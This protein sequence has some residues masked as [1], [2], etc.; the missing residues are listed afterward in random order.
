MD[1]IKYTKSLMLSK[2]VE[3][4]K[5]FELTRNEMIAIAMRTKSVKSI[6][7]VNLTNKLEDTISTLILNFDEISAVLS[8]IHSKMECVKALTSLQQLLQSNKHDDAKV[9]DMLNINHNVLLESSSRYFEN[10]IEEDKFIDDVYGKE[11][12]P[13]EKN[14][15]KLE[16][17]WI[18]GYSPVEVI[19]DLEEVQV[20]DKD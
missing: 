19:N 10:E 16:E 3:F 7:D 12:E 8:L 6:F 9:M 13:K 2:G 20:W 1:G 15:K 5:S 11:E 18:Q 17:A 14:F 4:S